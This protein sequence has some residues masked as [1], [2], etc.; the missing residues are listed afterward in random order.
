[1]TFAPRFS[2]DGQRVIMSL[3]SGANSN[4]FVLDLRSRTTRQ[5]TKTPAIDTAPSYSPDGGQ[6]VFESDRGGSQ[7]IYLMNADGSGQQRISRGQGRYS[8]PVWSPRGD[9]IAFTKLVNGNFAIGVMRP[10][11][12]GERIL[13]EG[14]HNEGPT[15][16][17]NGRVLMFF[18]D[19][20]GRERGTKA[21]RGR[22]DGPQRAAGVIPR[23]SP[24]TRRGRPCSNSGDGR[25]GSG[26]SRGIAGLRIAIQ[27]P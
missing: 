10:D 6:V 2:P 8:T 18:R 7:Q 19:T 20:P 16:A 22:S 5:L 15:W 26:I 1:M 14:F 21:L 3:Q 13:T 23:A 9:Y 24:R 25:H 17:P 11:G 12:S 4:I 27:L